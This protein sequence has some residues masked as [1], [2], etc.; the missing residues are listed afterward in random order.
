MMLPPEV[1]TPGLLEALLAVRALIH[2]RRED[3]PVA[4][5]E[6]VVE[7]MSVSRAHVQAEVAADLS[8]TLAEDFPDA[9]HV[10][11]MISF[12]LRQKASTR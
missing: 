12:E 3:E 4:L 9:A 1:D 6:V 10:L 11:D 5:A 7:T 8:D 2:G